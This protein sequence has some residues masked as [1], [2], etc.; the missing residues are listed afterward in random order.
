MPAPTLSPEDIARLARRAGLPLPEHR[1]ADVTAT[2]NAI[3]SVL[4]SL[5]TLPP[6]DTPPAPAFSAVPRPAV[7]R[8]SS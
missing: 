1:L 5:R 7:P 3:D 4:S 8:K 2:V 6:G